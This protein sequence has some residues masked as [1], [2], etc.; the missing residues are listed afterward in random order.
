MPKSSVIFASQE[1]S[2]LFKLKYTIDQR[3][4]ATSLHWEATPQQLHISSHQLASSAAPQMQST[5][6]PHQHLT[7]RLT[8]SSKPDFVR[9]LTQSFSSRHSRQD[10]PSTLPYVRSTGTLEF[11]LQPPRVFKIELHKSYKPQ[12]KL[13]ISPHNPSKCNSSS[14]SIPN[15]SPDSKTISE[16]ET[17]HP[18]LSHSHNQSSASAALLN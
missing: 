13:Y 8:H 1:F 9:P 12:W 11:P 15:K 2:I 6:N 18:L 7:L 14:H 16:P 10:Y 3:I 5:V 4:K 17:T